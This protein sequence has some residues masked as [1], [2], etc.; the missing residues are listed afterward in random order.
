MAK[1]STKDVARGVSLDPDDQIVGG[2]LFGPGPAV[3]KE[4]RFGMF[5]YQGKRK[6]VVALLVTFEREGG[7]KHVESYTVGNGWKPSLDGEYLIPRAGQAG[8]SDSCKAAKY[9]AALRDECKMPK[10]TIARRVSVLDGIAGTLD[11]KP[12]EK[13][14]GSERAG[15][16]LIFTDVDEAPWLA[17]GASAGKKRM[18]HAT[19]P[20]VEDE[21]EDEKPQRTGKAGKPA[22]A[23]A[24]D[25][26]DDDKDE[27]D[28]DVT[29]EAVEALISALDEGPIKLLK[30][31]GAILAAVKKHPKRKEIAALAASKTFLQREQGWAFDGRTVSLD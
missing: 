19:T 18:K 14:E 30:V 29:E 15:S 23:V 31:E 20:V 22:V 5:D 7:E 24:D 1:D 28:E 11:R 3:A 27:S 4:H 25:G 9:I 6:A 21:E 13:I 2:G 16:I 17:D 26:D 12:L 8:L 10:G